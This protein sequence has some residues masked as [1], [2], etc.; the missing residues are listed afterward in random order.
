MGIL[1]TLVT[2][3]I[4]LIYASAT[5]G[6]L[7][8]SEAALV[9]LAFFYLLF[10]RKKI[11]VEMR[12]PIMVADPGGKVTIVMHAKNS[13]YISCTKIRYRI[14]GGHAFL[15]KMRGHWLDGDVVDPGETTYQD[16]IYPKIAGNYTFELEK[17]RFYD[18]T[19]IFFLDRKMRQIAQVQ[20]LPEIRDVRVRIS[21]HVRNFYGDADTYDDFRP[22]EDHSEI[23]AV[24]EFRA[25]D[26]IQSIH[27]KLTAKADELLVREDSHPLACPL[28]FLLE[29]PR[30][31]KAGQLR[32][33]QYHLS[34]AASIVFSLMDASCP[35]YVAWYSGSRQDIVRVRVDDEESYYV[36][37]TAYMQDCSGQPPFAV[38]EMYREKYRFDH[39]IYTMK[40]GTDGRLLLNEKTLA[41]FDGKKWESTLEKIELIL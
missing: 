7:A 17:I 32:G 2:F 14:K 36:F 25:G 24:R 33:I 30:V 8:F 5:L 31:K 22:G 6:L 40:L 21:E 13:G 34:V 18:M 41:V 29:N 3:Y 4:A 11:E 9:V 23:F 15:K 28:V 19:G 10:T 1:V 20:I 35:H 39:A 16:V 27:W 38:E 37:L 26:R 12:I